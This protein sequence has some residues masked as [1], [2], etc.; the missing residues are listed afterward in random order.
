[1]DDVRKVEQSCVW[2]KQ[3]SRL[4]AVAG[5]EELPRHLRLLWAL[6]E[7]RRGP[8]PRQTIQSIG[9]AAVALADA[10]GLAA[11]SMKAVAE[12]LGMTTMSLYRYL[13]AKEDLYEVMLDQAY[14]PPPVVEP[15]SGAGWRALLAGWAHAL[16]RALLAH[17][18]IVEVPTSTPPAT[19]HVLGWTDRGVAAFSGTGL[20][21]QQ[22]L[23]CLLLVDGFVRQHVRL[24]LQLGLAP[25][26]SDGADRGE[27]SG[28]E[29]YAL[30]LTQLVDAAR[31]PHLAEASS[32]L[33]DDGDFYTEELEFG[34][35]VVLDGI[36]VLVERASRAG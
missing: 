4:A 15:V 36:A 22:R 5:P 18:W 31:L 30:R 3:F 25:S 34:L 33:E 27:R 24:S 1:V 13:D 26:S 29:E 12:A 10:H 21:G 32:A 7:A 9:T 17:P 20:D 35:G 28:G 19:P 23:S 8:R 16:A 6:P 2:R 14:G 11:V